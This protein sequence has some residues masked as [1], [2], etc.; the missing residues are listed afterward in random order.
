MKLQNKPRIV[1]GAPRSGSGKTLVSI[2]LMQALTAAG[3][4]V[5]AY[6]CGP[7]YIDPM[8]HKKILG[9]TSRNLDL[10][11]ADEELAK[12]LFAD[13]AASSGNTDNTE[14]SVIE[15]VMGL[16]DGIGTTDRASTYHLAKTLAAPIILIVDSKG[17]GR[18]VIAEIAG[19][20]M[21]DKMHL[22]KGVI[23][24]NMS[25]AF[26]EAVKPK[27]EAELA[28][29]VLGYFPFQKDIKIESRYLGLKL[30]DEID[31]IKQMVSKAAAELAKTVDLKRIE[32]IAE[33]ALP[34]EYEPLETLLQIPARPQNRVR[35]ALA[36]DE[37][38]CFYYDDNIK[39]LEKLGAEIVEFSPLHDKQ[40][41]PEISGLVLGG[42][43]PEQFAEKLAA[44]QSMK[45]SV[46]A[47]LNAGL[48]S[49]AEC[50]GFMY[51]N[52][53]IETQDG[54]QHSMVGAIKGT[55]RFMNKLVRFGY[56]SISVNS[57]NGANSGG[58]TGGF[59]AKDRAIKAHEFHYFDSTDNGASCTAT[60][61]GGAKSW[62]CVHCGENHWWG[63]PH[64]YFLSDVEF[65]KR[66]LAACALAGKKE[67]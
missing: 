38:F 1:L 54:K 21:L 17:M 48:P 35:I 57:A 7:D 49:I 36:R 58:E 56:I 30:P 23:L 12:S 55:C 32:T 4:K 46:L 5:S 16:F 19:F 10:F 59:L 45:D 40:L 47:A 3:K 42:G 33:E 34:L 20:L 66:F 65:A 43:Y 6:K 22:I 13:S 67:Q 29:P 14:I 64:L 53:S 25:A 11:F 39:L 44:N 52:E 61:P 9:V 60:K 2:A 41:P 37:A 18:S 26:Y 15:G 28:V 31:G 8:F 51:L 62:N 24:N 27:I 50:G 63:F